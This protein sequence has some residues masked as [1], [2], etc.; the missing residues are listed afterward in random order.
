MPNLHEKAEYREVSKEQQDRIDVIR[1]SFS[2]MYDV[3]EHNCKDSREIEI[4]TSRLEE[5]QMWAIKS[6]SRE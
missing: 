4:A 3:L 1:S 2:K 6:I 5:A